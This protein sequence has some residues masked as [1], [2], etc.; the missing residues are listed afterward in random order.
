MKKQNYEKISCR[1]VQR[2]PVSHNNIFSFPVGLFFWKK[3][4]VKGQMFMIAAI[5]MIIGFILLRNL[6]SLPDISQSKAF[7]DTS[8]LD[9]NLKNLNREYAYLTGVASMQPTPNRTGVEYLHNF[10][11]YIS[12]EFDSKMLFVYVFSNGTSSNF[13]VTVGNFL[14]DNISGILNATSS[15]PTGRIFA[16]NDTGNTTLEFNYTA[17]WINVTLNY[18]YQ[19]RETVERFN[20]NASSRNFATSFFDVTIRESGFFVRSK[21]TY[22]RTWTIS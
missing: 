2:T 7:Q 12:G 1:R 6:L 17:G 13:S 14:E 5:F 4:R 18:T 16:L 3:K 22:N 8:Y 21:G 15:T 20:F 19:N 11:R 10:S 9:K